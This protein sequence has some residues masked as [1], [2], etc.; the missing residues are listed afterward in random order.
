M[1]AIGT[2]VYAAITEAGA[3][4]LE[5]LATAMEVSAADPQ[6]RAMVARYLSDLEL[7]DG[8]EALEIG[9][10]TGAIARVLAA[11]P[12]IGRVVG[13]DPSPALIETARR[14]ADGVE[15]LAFREGDGLSLELADA[16]FDV[17][18]AHRVLSHVP[19][20]E[21]VLAEAFRVL[22]PGGSLALFDG[23]Y[24][25]ITVALGDADPLQTCVRAFAP[26]Y[27]TDAWIARRLPRMVHAAGF[28]EGRVRSHGYVEVGDP[29][30]MLSIV[31]RG[32]AALAASGRIG[33]PLAEALEAE[34]ERRVAA[35]AFF[36]HIAYVSLTAV[37]P[38]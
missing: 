28:V 38:G 36:G 35:N 9:C 17:V 6:H 34:A 16:S 8:A 5:S 2:D 19:A 24:A 1:T 29:R 23:D 15:N 18:V 25:T 31:S 11:W 12:G 14:L 20:P 32:A 10:G 37:K 30:Y 3:E 4:V 27:I 13:V 26:A 21:R 7:P 33:A 22:R